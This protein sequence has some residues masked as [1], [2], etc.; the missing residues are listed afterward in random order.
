MKFLR[1]LD[2]FSSP[3]IAY[4]HCDVPCGVYET[5]T[6]HH[7]IE[8]VRSMTTKL[9][10][11]DGKTDLQSLNSIARMVATKEEWAHKVKTEI[12][13]LWTDHFKPEHAEKWPDLHEKV[14]KA[15]KQ[16][17][18]VKRE[19]N[20]DAVEKLATMVDEISHRFAESKK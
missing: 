11:L 13:I 8:T 15:C 18:A 1:L 4:A 9:K 2:K 6:L 10:D 16:C 7:G 3:K 14:W 17:S 20:P 5:D 12:L 19:V